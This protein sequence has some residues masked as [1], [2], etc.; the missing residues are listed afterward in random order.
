MSR[1]RSRAVLYTAA[2][3]VAAVASAL[4]ASQ[5]VALVGRQVTDRRPAPL[6]TTEIEDELAAL[7]QAKASTTTAAVTASTSTSSTTSIVPTSTEA[8][9]PSTRPPSSGRSST[10]AVTS[11]GSSSTSA[12]PARTATK[13]AETR[14]YNLEGGTVSLRFTSS[15]VTVVFA[16]PAA[17]FDVE[18]EPEHVN[19][20]KVEFE[21]ETH[22]SRVDGWWEGGPVDRIREEDR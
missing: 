18:V 4:V 5:G 3:V 8:T 7:E 11:P 16:N 22:R 1:L 20:V 9:V 17:G 14:T 6:S 2:W 19:G 13:A 15:G 21:S 10:T 12:P